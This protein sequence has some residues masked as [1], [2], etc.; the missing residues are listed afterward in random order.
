[1]EMVEAIERIVKRML[2]AKAVVGKVTAID[3]STKTCTVEVEGGYTRYGVR[4]RADEE[5]SSTGLY[6]IPANNSRV[7]IEMIEGQTGMWYVAMV[8]EVDTI[9]LNGDQFRS[10]MKIEV[11]TDRLRRLEGKVNNLIT[12]Y[13]TH[14]HTETGGS[15]A[16]T[17]SI[18]TP[19]SPLTLESDLENPKVKH[20]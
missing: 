19:I 20:G 7:V 8:S 9:C 18:E 4:L 3:T 16:P 13:N 17:T 14:Q 12:L 15:T 6:I 11:V 5:G 10:L 2:K 1:M